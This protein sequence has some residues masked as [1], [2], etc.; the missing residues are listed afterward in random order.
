LS[1]KFGKT[2]AMKTKQCPQC[3]NPNVGLIREGKQYFFKKH[4][5]TSGK[6]CPGSFSEVNRVINEQ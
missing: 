2:K 3:N 6:Q 4:N 1:W 5:R